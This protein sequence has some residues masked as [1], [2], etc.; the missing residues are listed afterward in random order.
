MRMHLH[1]FVFRYG[2]RGKLAYRASLMIRKRSI[3]RLAYK[4]GIARLSA[5]CHNEVR[6]SLS[7]FL[8]AVL[9]KA[10]LYMQHEGLKTIC[11]RHIHQALEFLGLRLYR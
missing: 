10:T 7:D 6:M 11:E 8:F 2:K 4:G 5:K 1:H 3:R 9:Q